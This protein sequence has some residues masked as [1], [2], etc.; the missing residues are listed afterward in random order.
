MKN[1]KPDPARAEA[2]GSAPGSSRDAIDESPRSRLARLYAECEVR[3]DHLGEIDRLY[4]ERILDHRETYR[5]VGAELGIPWWFVGII[6][7]LESSFDFGCH[8]HNGDPL[9]GA[10]R[11]GARGG[12]PRPGS[13]PSPGT[14]AR[15]T[16]SAARVS[17][18]AGTGRS[19]RPSTGSSGT[20]ASGTGSTAAPRPT[21]G[22]TP[23]TTRRESTSPTGASTPRRC[24]GSAAGRPSS[25]VWRNAASSTPPD[26]ST[27]KRT[28]P[29]P[30]SIS[31]GRSCGA[32]G[33]PPGSVTCGGCR[34]G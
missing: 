12:G 9:T 24:R 32:G 3:S 30:G 19:E 25:V 4:V 27:G 22:A 13:P 10:H 16:R 20:T 2:A 17:R 15:S 26:P 23:G 6:H 18:A 11:P 28:E 33:T 1:E 5:A 14:R 31:R 21:F 7:G 29:G 34:S 8:L